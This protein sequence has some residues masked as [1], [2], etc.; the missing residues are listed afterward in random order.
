MHEAGFRM[1]GLDPGGLALA[2]RAGRIE[3]QVTALEQVRFPARPSR[4]ERSAGLARLDAEWQR[5]GAP[6]PLRRRAAERYW[7]RLG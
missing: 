6:E 2:E 4:A 1:P 3:A 5:L 7:R